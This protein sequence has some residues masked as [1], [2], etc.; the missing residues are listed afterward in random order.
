[1]LRLLALIAENE[2]FVDII[3][4]MAKRYIG[5]NEVALA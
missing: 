3:A 2:S 4:L 5:I 1:M